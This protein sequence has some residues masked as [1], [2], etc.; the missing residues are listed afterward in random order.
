MSVKLKLL[1]EVVIIFKDEDGILR[2]T[3]KKEFVL[4]AIKDRF[5]LT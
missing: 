5:G 4:I 1:F 3:S 2:C